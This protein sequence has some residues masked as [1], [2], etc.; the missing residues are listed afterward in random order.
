[1]ISTNYRLPF[2]F[3][4]CAQVLSC[5]G[6]VQLVMRVDNPN[7]MQSLQR[8]IQFFSSLAETGAFSGYQIPPWESTMKLSHM[9]STQGNELRFY[10]ESCYLADEALIVLA[11]MLLAAHESTPIEYIKILSSQQ[12][13]HKILKLA[14]KDKATYPRAYP[15]LPFVLSNQ[16]PEGGGYSFLIDLEKPLEQ[17]HEAYLN[18]A[19]GAWV[20]TVLNGGFSAFP[21]D[22][23]RCYVEPDEKEV[24]TYENKVEWAVFKLLADQASLDGLINLLIAFHM[25]CQKI[26]HINIS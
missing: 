24:T 12:R 23:K 15:H 16:E 17:R 9:I 3:N 18:R 21:T 19:L 8:I 26:M 11:H 7:H 4:Y 25:R 14:S 5:G 20:D 13:D 6:E 2:Q 10:A 22:P 1:M